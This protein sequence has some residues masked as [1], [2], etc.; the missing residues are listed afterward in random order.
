MAAQEHELSSSSVSLVSTGGS[1]A[2]SS[3]QIGPESMQ[4]EKLLAVLQKQVPVTAEAVAAFPLV[5]TNIS[6]TE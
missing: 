2:G 3:I 4:Q 6:K 5:S 1:I